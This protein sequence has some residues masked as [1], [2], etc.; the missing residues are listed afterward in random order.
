MEH[1][2]PSAFAPN[3]QATVSNIVVYCFGN[4]GGEASRC[5]LRKESHLPFAKQGVIAG[6]MSPNFSKKSG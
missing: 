1:Y 4:L 3:A 6:R 2:S 5:Y